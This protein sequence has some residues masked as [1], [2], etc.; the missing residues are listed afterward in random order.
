MTTGTVKWFSLEKR[1]GFITPDEGDAI[2]F[3]HHKFVD[4]ED[5]KGFEIGDRVE[6]EV[7]DGPKGCEARNPNL[8]GDH[9]NALGIRDLPLKGGFSKCT[10]QPES[11][12]LTASGWFLGPPVEQVQI[13]LEEELLGVA[14]LDQRR[15]D[16]FK[17]FPEYGNEN[18][19]WCFEQKIPHAPPSSASITANVHYQNEVVHIY[20]RPV[21]LVERTINDPKPDS[22]KSDTSRDSFHAKQFSE[23]SS[24]PVNKLLFDLAPL[25]STELGE[26]LTNDEYFAMA[27]SAR[28][29][30]FFGYLSEKFGIHEKVL[31]IMFDYEQKAWVG[32]IKRQLT[33]GKVPSLRE[34]IASRM[35]IYKKNATVMREILKIH[36]GPTNAFY[37][38]GCQFGYMMVEAASLGFKKVHGGEINPNLISVPDR[39]AEFSERAYSSELAY[40]VG[41]FC[42]LD[43]KRHVYDVVTCVD[44]LEHTPDIEEMLTRMIDLLTPIG[45]IYIYQGNAQSLAIATK[46]PHYHLPAISALSSDLTLRILEHLGMVSSK[47]PYVVQQWPTLERIQACAEKN[48]AQMDVI[49]HE[50]NIRSGQAFPKVGDAQKLLS[51]LSARVNENLMPHLS[52]SLKKETQ[53][54][55]KVFLLQLEDDI[56]NSD[57]VEFARKYLMGSWNISIRRRA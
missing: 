3:V 24:N 26:C 41:D 10:Y 12:I 49:G 13:L 35:E 11:T 40:T 53:K 23:Q 14:I 47:A 1:F 17:Q 42:K 27:S 50:T 36:D 48:D 32:S 37:D 57:E 8:I 39:L 2:A 20:K 18:A 54:A 16:V 43:L 6:Y 38:V 34:R 15:S 30:K 9:Q 44:V 29:P 52:R 56:L 51:A 7:V 55:V 22:T 45:M 25:T 46:E 5:F 33:S 28:N 19:G 21:A 4:A 31:G